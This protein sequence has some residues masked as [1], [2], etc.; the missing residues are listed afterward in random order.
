[1]TKPE[2]MRGHGGGANPRTKF[3]VVCQ[4]RTKN[5]TVGE[6]RTVV[7]RRDFTQAVC[8]THRIATVHVADQS[9]LCVSGECNV[10]PSITGL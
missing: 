3:G 7:R 2:F 9:D 6:G 1:M 4:I 5:A 8:M 10:R